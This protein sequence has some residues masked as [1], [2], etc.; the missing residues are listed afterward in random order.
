MNQSDLLVSPSRPVPRIAVVTGTREEFVLLEGTMSR[1]A[2]AHWCELQV[3]VAGTHLEARLGETVREVESRF[4]IAARVAM[5]PAD[6]TRR[7]MAVAAAEGLAKFSQGFSQ[8]DPDLVLI[9]GDRAEVFVSSLAASYLGIPV[10]QVH[11]GDSRGDSCDDF[12][13]DATSR[14]ASVHLSATETIA[15]RLSSRKVGGDLHV[16]GSPGL[17][18]ACACPRRP[19]NVLAEKL[20]LKD[21]PWLV[22]FHHESSGAPEASG[23]EMDV[24]LGAAVEFAESR[25]AHVVV[26][27]P[28]DDASDEAVFEALERW[29]G[30]ECLH[31]FRSLDREDFLDLLAH[32]LVLIGNSASGVTESAA[33]GIPVVNVGDRQEGR[34]RDAN[35]V[36]VGVTHCGIVSAVERA[37][38]DEGVR[39]AVS[40]RR[41]V[42]GD[43]RTAQ[44]IVTILRDFLLAGRATDQEVERETET[45]PS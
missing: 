39:E 17:D 26:L 12:Q 14:L 42:Y 23:V 25:G 33:L 22:V 31:V 3:I 43:G 21:E 30:T 6:D 44:R 37:L 5:E 11:G 32:G 19:R 45:S 40:S 8:L 20:E 38:M 36:D 10:A 28:N 29:R 7:G 9:S 13:R 41:S 34:E 24:V 15:S 35:V 27:C 18:S 2:K 4:A 16:V 1:L